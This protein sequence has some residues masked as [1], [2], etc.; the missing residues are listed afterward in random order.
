[1][2]LIS[3]KKSVSA[4]PRLSRAISKHGYVFLVIEGVQPQPPPLHRKEGCSRRPRP[5]RV[6][7]DA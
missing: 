7:V 6:D 4:S 1:M 3:I 2:R 5:S